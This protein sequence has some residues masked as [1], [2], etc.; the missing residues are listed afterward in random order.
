MYDLFLQNWEWDPKTVYFAILISPWFI[1]GWTALELAKSPKV[2]VIFKGCPGP[3]IKDLDEEILAKEDEHEEYEE[4][5]DERCR[6]R[7]S[8]IIRNLRKEIKSLNDLL[9]VL[10]P[11]YTSWPKDI[12]I[13][14]ALLVDVK[15]DKMQQNTYMRILGKLGKISPGNLFHNAATMSTGFSWCPTSLFYIPL[16]NYSKAWLKITDNGIRGKWRII[17]IDGTLEQN[18]LWNGSHPLRRQQLQETLR[19]YPDKCRLL[20]ECG[21]KPV[22][23]ALLVREMQEARGIREPLLC[24]YVGALYLRQELNAKKVDEVV[25]VHSNTHYLKKEEQS[26]STSE[27]KESEMLRRAVWRG[28][29]CRI[30]GASRKSRLE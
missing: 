30:Q 21:A 8:R 27:S 23:R 24:Q 16:H 3:V 9:T 17:P 1:R 4:D 19:K 7:A 13:I 18:C 11:R 6:K 15:P 12:S 2:K 5:G 26:I 20:A 14:S 28:R 29:L 10:G 22:R 25:I